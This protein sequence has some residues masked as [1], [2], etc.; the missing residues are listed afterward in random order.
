[1]PEIIEISG[2]GQESKPAVPTQALIAIGVV[3]LAVFL[4]GR[5]FPLRGGGSVPKPEDF[6][7]PGL[8]GLGVIV[9]CRSKDRDPRRPARDQ[10]WCLWTSDKKRI[11]GRHPTKERA[12]RQERLIQMRKHGR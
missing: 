5:L 1:M 10:K 8:E 12:L 3:G 6:L 7:I 9:P 4:I 11:L 2:L